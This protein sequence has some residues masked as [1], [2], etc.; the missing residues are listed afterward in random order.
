M[1][2]DRQ[3]RA[4]EAARLEVMAFIA[5]LPDARVRA[6]AVMRFLEGKSW[7]SIARRLHYERTSPAKQLRKFLRGKM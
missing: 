3:A 2:I 5:T 6:I 4:V 1:A 7:E